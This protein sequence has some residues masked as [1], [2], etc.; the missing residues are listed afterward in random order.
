MALSCR[1]PVNSSWSLESVR[2]QIKYSREVIVKMSVWMKIEDETMTTCNLLPKTWI[3]FISLPFTLG[4]V[5][6]F[7]PFSL[8]ECAPNTLHEDFNKGHICVTW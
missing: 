8:N 4:T 2:A 6:D 7:S 1:G 3:F 5:C